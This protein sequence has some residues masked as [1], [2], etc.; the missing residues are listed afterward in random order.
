MQSPDQL[1]DPNPTA[2]IPRTNDTRTLFDLSDR[3]AIVTGANTGK[4][5]LELQQ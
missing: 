1:E 5:V 4:L 3:V 2:K